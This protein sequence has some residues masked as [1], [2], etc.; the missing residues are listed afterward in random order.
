MKVID[1]SWERFGAA[2]FVIGR[3]GT[4][5]VTSVCV[6]VRSQLAKYPE[7]SFAVRLENPSGVTYDAVKVEMKDGQLIWIVTDTDTSAAGEGRIQIVMYGAEG[8][9][10]KTQQGKTIV[11]H[12]LN[13]GGKPP[14]PVQAWLDTAQELAK[15]A[16]EAA[17]KA[18][19]EADR[20]ENAVPRGFGS[21]N[22]GKLVFIGADGKLVPLKLGN[23]FEI[24]D[25][26]LRIKGQITPPEVPDTPEEPDEPAEV[27]LTIDKEGN[28]TL[29]GAT[30]NVSLDG[31]GT[32]TD[33]DIIVDD[34]GNGMIE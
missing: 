15:R 34:N 22:A 11:G 16:E 13:G 20:A 1:T 33:A 4:N 29:S 28:A 30:L 5:N 7:A 6:D 32:I 31:E 14:D 27:V 8:E 24:A 9:I 19:E 26:V 3:R 21:E 10:D 25:G 23:E 18:K 12:S 2:P 17:Q